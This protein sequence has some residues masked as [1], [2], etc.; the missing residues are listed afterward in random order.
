M[1]RMENSNELVTLE[2]CRRGTKAYAEYCMRKL[3]SEIEECGFVNG[4]LEDGFR[5]T[6]V[7]ILIDKILQK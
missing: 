3:I 6:N 4:N 2:Q 1:S 7:D 5:I